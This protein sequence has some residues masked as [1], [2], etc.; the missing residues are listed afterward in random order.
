MEGAFCFETGG[1][2]EAVAS[3]GFLSLKRCWDEV[4]EAGEGC[5]SILPVCSPVGGRAPG[6]SPVQP[7]CP[8]VT[9]NA[10]SSGVFLEVV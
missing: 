6:C 1:C 9:V 7:V 5:L 8:Q 4:G 10:V 3:K 2:G